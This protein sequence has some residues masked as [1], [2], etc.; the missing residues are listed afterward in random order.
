MLEQL[1]PGNE[2]VVCPIDCPRAPK[3][4][5]RSSHPAI[6]SELAFQFNLNRAASGAPSIAR[7]VRPPRTTSRPA[8]RRFGTRLGRQTSAVMVYGRRVGLTR[9]ARRSPTESLGKIPIIHWLASFALGHRSSGLEHSRTLRDCTAHGKRASVGE[10]GGPPP[11][12]NTSPLANPSNHGS[13]ARAACLRE[14]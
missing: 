2:P 9:A 13:F 12:W 10:C 11:L 5:N 3:I 1:P 14:P 6:G 8:R 7:P 4:A